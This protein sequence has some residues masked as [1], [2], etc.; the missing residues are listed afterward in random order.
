M[1]NFM[2]LAPFQN[3]EKTDDTIPRKRQDRRKDGKDG[4]TLFYRTFAVTIRGFK[5][6]FN[7]I[8]VCALPKQMKCRHFF[9]NLFLIREFWPSLKIP[10]RYRRKTENCFVSLFYE[11]SQFIQNRKKLFIFFYTSGLYI[12]TTHWTLSNKISHVWCEHQ[13]M[14]CLTWFFLPNQLFKM[15]FAANKA[16]ISYTRKWCSGYHYCTTSFN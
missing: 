7:P 6:K 14:P 5:N 11:Y 9:A 15:K 8:W 12:S 13:R 1:H 16:N 3:L 10:K 2:F 4:Q